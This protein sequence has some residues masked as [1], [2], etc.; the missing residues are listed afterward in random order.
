MS[1]DRVRAGAADAAGQ[2]LRVSREIAGEPAHPIVAEIELERE[3]DSFELAVSETSS[4]Q[5]VGFELPAGSSP[6]LPSANEPRP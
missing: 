2:G 4:F 6:A 3:A 5:F 1:D